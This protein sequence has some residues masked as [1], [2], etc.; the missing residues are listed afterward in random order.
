MRME[1]LATGEGPMMASDAPKT[2]PLRDSRPEREPDAPVDMELLTAAVRISEEV[3]TSRGLR[4]RVDAAAIAD[5]VRLVY[6]D[7]RQG[8]AQEMAAQALDRILAIARPP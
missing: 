3:L 6:Q 4:D 8:R 2:A 1:W 7:L 5:L